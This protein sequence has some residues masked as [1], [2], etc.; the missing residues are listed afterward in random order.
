L[1]R[2]SDNQFT[3][4]DNSSVS[5]NRIEISVTIDLAVDDGNG[6]IGIQSVFGGDA[7]GAEGKGGWILLVCA[8]VRDIV[9][10]GSLGSM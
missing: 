5:F 6:S 1:S 9:P 2:E 7:G 3:I 4:G 8:R 10:V